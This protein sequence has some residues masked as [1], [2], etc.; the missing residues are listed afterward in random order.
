M[1]VYVDDF[2]AWEIPQD[3]M[4]STRFTKRGLPDRRF[5]HDYFNSWLLNKRDG[6]IK[7]MET[8]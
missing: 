7:A 3:V 4:N 2:G 5:R 6:A 8:P 1:N